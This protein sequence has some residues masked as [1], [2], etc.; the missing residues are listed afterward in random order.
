[1]IWRAAQ[2]LAGTLLLATLLAV[3]VIRWASRSRS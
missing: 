3:V 2:L 1:V